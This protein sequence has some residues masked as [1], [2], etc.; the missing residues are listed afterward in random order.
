MLARSS[1]LRA[2]GDDGE[3]ELGLAG[4]GAAVLQFL[5][6]RKQFCDGIQPRVWHATR[7]RFN[8]QPIEIERS[9]FN[10]FCGVK[11]RFQR[12]M[13]VLL[14]VQRSTFSISLGC[15]G[16][17]LKAQRSRFKVQG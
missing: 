13:F 3:R 2:A 14:N 6:R 5:A 17:S 4:H 16:F 9:T 7:K 11:T 10:L 8:V 15:T 12:S 1:D